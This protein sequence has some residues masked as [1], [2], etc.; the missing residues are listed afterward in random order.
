MALL[1]LMDFGFIETVQ[2]FK[3]PYPSYKLNA[4]GNRAFEKIRSQVSSSAQDVDMLALLDFDRVGLRNPILRARAT[5]AEALMND[6][7]K[8][9]SP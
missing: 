7:S 3:A 8:E 4:L 1:E 9:R 5:Y 6:R 2:F